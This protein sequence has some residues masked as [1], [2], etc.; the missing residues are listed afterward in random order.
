MANPF[1]RG[2][3]RYC[4]LVVGFLG[5]TGVALAEDALPEPKWGDPCARFTPD[6]SYVTSTIIMRLEK[7]E[8]HLRVPIEYFED[9]WDRVD[10]FADTAQLFSVEM[11]SFDPISRP[12]ASER[13]KRGER[14]RPMTFLISD[15]VPFDR[16]GPIR[17]EQFMM[18]GPDGKHLSQYPRHAGPFGL[19]QIFSSGFEASLDYQN[20]VFV[21]EGPNGDV[22]AIFDC[23]KPTN[24]MKPSCSQNFTVAG[25]D[26]QLT[27][28]LSDLQHWDRLQSD[29]SKF[30]TCATTFK[31]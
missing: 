20:D 9:A 22:R 26:V 1:E 18:P 6:A 3:M 19:S 24:V 8:V 5:L 11:G 30:L 25:L 27:F 7:R 13:K 31:S 15:V 2:G 28:D 16:L 14:R 10:G 12:E 17:A 29:V 4:A 23:R 21:A